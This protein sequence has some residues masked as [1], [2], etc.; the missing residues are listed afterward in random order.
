MSGM[1][2]RAWLTL[3]LLILAAPAGAAEIT[4]RASVLDGDTIEIRGAR[5]RL[6]GI[7][8]P[9]SGQ[10]CLDS[11]GE[12]YRCGQSAAFALADRIGA[13]NV[14]CELLDRDQYNRHI[15]RC[16]LAETDLNAWMVRQG[17]AVAYRRFS[18]EY[19]P[20][21]NAA[22]GER[23]GLWHGDFDMPWDWRRG[24]RRILEG[25]RRAVA[26]DRGDCNIKGNI[27]RSGERIYHMPG[28]QHYEQTRIDESRGQRWFCS[29]EEA[30]AAGW[31]P[32]QR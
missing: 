29:E 11:T 24:D 18:I 5:V 10:W 16:H 32:A 26:I 7:D 6:H 17:Q 12:G 15:G 1:R 8:A 23:L 20:E 3:F 30:Q 28:Q 22:R 13:R 25:G 2:F 31:R 21:E 4:G 19:V 27:S 14:R 9:E